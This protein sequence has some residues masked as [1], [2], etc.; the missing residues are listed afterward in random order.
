MRKKSAYS[1]S[2]LC[3]AFGVSRSGY[4]HH[5]SPSMTQQRA[6]QIQLV[7]AM[8]AIHR[9]LKLKVYGSPRMTTELQARGFGCSENTVARLMN[10]HGLAAKGAKT[11]KPP[12]TTTVDKKA[13][14]SPNKLVN[15]K[16]Q[17]FGEVL[18]ADITYIPTKEGW[19]NLSVVIDLFSRAVLGFQTSG[20]MPAGIVTDALQKAIDDWNIPRGLSTFHSD[21]G[22]QYTSQ[23]LRKQ[24][25]A[26]AFEQSMSA[27]GNC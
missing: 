15:Q 18:I 5:F 21:R 6:K 2:E 26:N 3:R 27:K 9:D 19:L 7:A 14:Y 16:S 8:R 11:F 1:T 4:R 24:L 12:K 17:H 13:K 20:A 25:H 22:S 10:Q 23:L